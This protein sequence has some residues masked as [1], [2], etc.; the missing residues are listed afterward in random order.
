[1]FDVAPFENIR[2][3]M[4]EVVCTDGVV[5]VEGGY[6]R[7]SSWVLRFATRKKEIEGLTICDVVRID[8]R[9]RKVLGDT[10][11]RGGGITKQRNRAIAGL[12]CDDH[13]ADPLLQPRELP[14]PPISKTQRGELVG[15]ADSW[16]HFTVNE[17]TVTAFVAESDRAKLALEY[18]PRI[19]ALVGSTAQRDDRRPQSEPPRVPLAI[20]SR[21]SVVLGP[22][23]WRNRR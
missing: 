7:N 14:P 3:H 22:Q 8:T 17:V 19:V 23:T 11:F 18:S 15:R 21:L 6:L 12:V 2:D 1:M 5:L 20:F 9:M 16:I 10:F 4:A 13:G